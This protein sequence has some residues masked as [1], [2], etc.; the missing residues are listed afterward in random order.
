VSR[1][2][3]YEV[4]SLR[5]DMENLEMNRDTDEKRP[6]NPPRR[7]AITW[8]FITTVSIL[9]IFNTAIF[10]IDGFDGGFALA[11]VSILIFIMGII[12]MAIYF[13]R[14]KVLDKMLRG[15]NLLA[16]WTYSE[17]EWRAYAEREHR[18]QVELNRGMFLMIAIIAVIVGVIFVIIEPDAL[19][20]TAIAIGGIIGIIGITAFSVT[21]YRRAQNRKLLGEV[22]L[23]RDGVY[24]NRE[25][26]TWKSLGCKLESASIDDK[27]LG[28]TI[29]VFNYSAPSRTGR[30]HFS[31]RVPVP[32][33]KEAEAERV[34]A[35]IK[36]AH[37]NSQHDI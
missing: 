21:F 5:V 19:L 1:P 16:H 9:G 32:L 29:L 35:E 34:L 22:Y 11:S 14:A 13:P 25:L 10:G 23:N 31:A 28:Q 2:T 37:L 7:T 18:E 20:S 4:S 15:E 6:V 3:R 30:D 17:N 24:I 27:Y 36:K 12:V 26:H 8:C 33:G